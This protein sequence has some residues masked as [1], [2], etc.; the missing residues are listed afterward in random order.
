MSYKN[1]ESER[2]E[3]CVSAVG[4]GDG[5]FIFESGSTRCRGQYQVVH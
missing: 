4:G 3:F 1:E 5:M 2:R